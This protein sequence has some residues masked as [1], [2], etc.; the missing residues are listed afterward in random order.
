MII[1]FF[2]AKSVNSKSTDKQPSLQLQ[3]LFI[4]VIYSSLITGML[5]IPSYSQSHPHSRGRDYT[6]TYTWRQENWGLLESAYHEEFVHLLRLK[7][8]LPN[9]W[10]NS[11]TPRMPV[12]P[13][14]NIIIILNLCQKW[15]SVAGL[16]RLDKNVAMSEEVLHFLINTVMYCIMTSIRSEKWVVGRFCCVKIIEYTYTNLMV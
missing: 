13:A 10:N 14:L 4:F 3:N 15:A 12:S 1:C 5:Y 11:Y 6:D 8:K 9:F 7:S 16:K 2:K